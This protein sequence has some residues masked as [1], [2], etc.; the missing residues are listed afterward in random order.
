M[1]GPLTGIRV[2]EFTGLGPGPFCGM[3]LAD[4]GAEVI[5]IDRPGANHD[6]HDV[7]ARSRRTITVDMKTPEGL[8]IVRELC[9]SA[10][11]LIEGYRP[12]VMER[13]GLGPDV[14]LADNPRLVYGRMTGWG[15]E[16][17]LA[18]VAGHDIN[19]IA[20]SGVLSTMG[21]TGG[22]PVQPVNYLGDFGGGGMLLAFGI[23]SA[24]LAARMGAPGQ[25]IDAAMTDGSA[26]LSGMTWQ[27]LAGGYWE[28]K[29]GSNWLDGGSHFYNTYVCKDGGF[30]SLGAIEPQFYAIL[31]QV[32]GITDDPAFD[33]HMDYDRWPAL[34]DRLEAIF[35]TKTRDEWCALMEG[36]DICFAPILSLSEAP[37]HPH[38]KQR[39]TFVPVVDGKL[40]PAPAP[41]FS[42]TPADA[43]R[44][45]TQPGSDGVQ[46]LAGLGYSPE[47][48]AALQAKGVVPPPPPLDLQREV[49]P[50]GNRLRQ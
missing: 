27:L 25:V 37:E 22:K 49:R 5:R 29:L 34:K 9:A 20:L 14:L 40:Q 50:F 7:L 43:P 44:G 15:Q 12:G 10:D 36:T 24:I 42:Q 23:V 1:A 8:K 18:Q 39:K 6:P 31:R 32:L 17:P 3:M 11:A 26:L 35:L 16:G 38:N 4:N 41:R 21:T 33:D 19:Y 45:A 28:E 13:L 47:Q 46:V 2:I 48:V 30:I